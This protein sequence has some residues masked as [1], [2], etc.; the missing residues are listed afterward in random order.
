MSDRGRRPKPPCAEEQEY[1]E[2]LCSMTGTQI[3][4]IFLKM[5]GD[6]VN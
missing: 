3:G 1:R 4:A 5:A 6:L 2:H